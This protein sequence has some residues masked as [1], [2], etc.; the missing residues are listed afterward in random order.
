[1]DCFSIWD[2]CMNISKIAIIYMGGTFGCVGEPLSPMPADNFLTVLKQYYSQSHLHFFASPIIKD[3][4]ELSAP[5]WLALA[6]YM[7]N[8]AKQQQYQQ[9]IIIH[10]T[11]TLAY[12]SAFLHHIFANKYQIILTGSQFP[13]LDVQ[14]KNLRAQSDARDNLDYAI[15]LM[16]QYTQGVYLTFHQQLF[17]GNSCYKKHTEHFDAFLGEPYQAHLPSPQ[18]LNI[19]QHIDL[20]ADLSQLQQQLKNTYIDHLY[21]LPISTWLIQETLLQKMLNP[22]KVLFIQSFGSGNM[23]YSDGLKETLHTLLDNDCQIIIG[24]QV[25]HGELSQK[26]ATGSWLQQ[27]DVLFDHHISQ[28]D[29]YARA[30]L[31]L[32]IYPQNWQ[33]YWNINDE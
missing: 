4:T 30:M 26:Y 22:P 1:M 33:Q 32:N 7:E 15:T 9:F 19:A 18:S 11:D 16:K 10:G 8:L 20:T 6:Q 13:I 12:A 25:L 5:D 27:L 24:S 3:S 23:P 28:A 17:Y 29:S 14:G 21:L 31:L 2:I